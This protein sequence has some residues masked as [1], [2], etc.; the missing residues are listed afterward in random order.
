MIPAA[1]LG[2]AVPASV[3]AAFR[4]AQH[5]PLGPRR[6][7]AALGAPLWVSRAERPGP[8][9]PQVT[10]VWSSGCKVVIQHLKPLLPPP[11]TPRVP[12]AWG[13]GG[14]AEAARGPEGRLAG[15]REEPCPGEKGVPQ[16]VRTDG[17]CDPGHPACVTSAGGAGHGRGQSPRPA[18]GSRTGPGH[19]RGKSACEGTGTQGGLF[20]AMG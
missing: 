4:A 14:S 17:G 13:P 12:A 3:A 15:R 9:G 7:P 16:A 6:P 20:L 8:R 5:L 18:P 10:V 2:Y 19:S 1:S 11:F